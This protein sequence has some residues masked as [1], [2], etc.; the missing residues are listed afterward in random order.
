M[1]RIGKTTQQ[2]LGI[3]IGSASYPSPFPSGLEYSAPARGTWNIVHTGML[4][5]EAHQVFICAQGCLRGVVL[6]A[7]EMG[8]QE[9]FS[10][11]A[12]RPENVLNGDMEKLIMD[13]M[14]RAGVSEQELLSRREIPTT[15][16]EILSWE[17]LDYVRRHPVLWNVPTH[18]LYGS[19]DA[20][21]SAPVLMTFAERIG[22]T[23]TVFENG[24]HWFHDKD[25]M[26]FLD[27][28]LLDHLRKAGSHE[29]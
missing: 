24:E 2:E 7:A 18:I 22:A 4:I 11:V 16:G 27:Q 12:V 26:S 15:G 23:I 9:R 29:E 3:S 1:I 6:T 8:A 20:I 5:P 13:L 14:V 19:Q 21:T 28:W 25:Q 17:Y 10:T